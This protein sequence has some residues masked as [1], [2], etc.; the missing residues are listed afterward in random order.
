MTAPGRAA[1]LFDLD[2][3]LTD[4]S[5]GIAACIRHALAALDAADPGDA[6]LRAC[7]GPP[8]RETFARLLATADAAH[9]ELALAHYRERYRDVGWRENTPYAGIDAALATLAARGARL[10]LCTS[11]PEVYARRILAHFG[12]DRHF[13]A[14]YGADLAG[15]LDDKRALLA[16]ILAR[17]D[18]DP[19]ACTM[20]GDR[21]HDMRAARAHGVQTVGVLW[22]FGGREELADAGV[23]VATPSELVAALVVQS[24]A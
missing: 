9:I 2:G 17:E 3:T 11:K 20:I 22:G 5:T 6:T 8:L 16:H 21:H 12:L 10:I 1:L 7:I 15:T 23:L 14:Q 18:L 19:A 24:S 13:S 4:N